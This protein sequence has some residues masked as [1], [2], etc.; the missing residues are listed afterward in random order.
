MRDSSLSMGTPETV[1]R[2]PSPLIT[3]VLAMALA[4]VCMSSLT[5]MSEDPRESLQQNLNPLPALGLKT[6]SNLLRMELY[7]TQ[8][9]FWSYFGSLTHLPNG[10]GQLP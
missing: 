8:V 7:L 3:R 1:G 2:M 6:H 4:R 9:Q 10:L 5:P